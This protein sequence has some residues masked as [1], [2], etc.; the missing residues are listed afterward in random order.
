VNYFFNMTPKLF[1]Y[2]IIKKKPLILRRIL[3]FLKC[4]FFNKLS[5]KQENNGKV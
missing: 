3:I 2:L 1:R 5:F 4:F